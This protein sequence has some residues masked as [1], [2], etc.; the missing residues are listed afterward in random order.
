[1]WEATLVRIAHTV[2][3]A[4]GI[5]KPAVAHS[6]LGPSVVVAMSFAFDVEVG[7]I[8]R[9]PKATSTLRPMRTARR[10]GLVPSRRSGRGRCRPGRAA[11]QA[12]PRLA[13]R[14][15]RA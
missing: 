7:P 13:S 3:A 15:L 1:M 11:H 5:S 14:A 12:S 6:R 8:P 10:R 9:A 2:L 4:I